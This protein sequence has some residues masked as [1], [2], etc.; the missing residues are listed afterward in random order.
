MVRTFQRFPFPASLASCCCGIS[1]QRQYLWV[2]SVSLTSSALVTSRQTLS[3]ALS[4][5]RPWASNASAG[6]SR[7]AF[8][9]S[10]CSLHEVVFVEGIVMVNPV[11]PPAPFVFSHGFLPLAF[12]VCT[13]MRVTACDVFPFFF[14]FA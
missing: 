13:L 6:K 5:T 8:E 7:R 1:L 11:P 3:V 14:H 9:R 4:Q 12:H 10:R 2:P